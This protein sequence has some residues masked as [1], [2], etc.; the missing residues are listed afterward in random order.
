M[1]SVETIQRTI[2]A[3]NHSA[4]QLFGEV[5]RLHDRGTIDHTVSLRT[6]SRVL[7]GENTTLTTLSII[8]KAAE[9]LK[10]P[11]KR[12]ARRAKRGSRRVAA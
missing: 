5:L 9:S 3:G 12:A 7:A 1:E 4:M 10:K 6:I 2:R 11:T 8:S